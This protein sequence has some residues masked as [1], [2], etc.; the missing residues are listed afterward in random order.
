MSRV[1]AIVTDFGGVLTSPLIESFAAFQEESGVSFQSL[2]MALAAIGARDGANPLFELETGR[3]SE[4]DFL[5]RLA[6]ELSEREGRE[7]AMDGF[8]AR[9]FGSLRPNEPM[10]DFMRRLSGRGLRMAICTNNVR[11]WEPLWRAMLP[12]DEIFPDVIDSAFVGFRKPEPEIY[13]IALERV[14]VE[15]SAALFVDDTEINCTAAR[16]LGMHAVWF[17][18]T[19]QAIAEIEAVLS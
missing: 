7:I 12:V 5:G 11:E 4:A 2:G 18:T 3:M 1:E 16:E 8:G 13:R 19:E 14:G 17:C 15:A 9:Y 6:E 10:I